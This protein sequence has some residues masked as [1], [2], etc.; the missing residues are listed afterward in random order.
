MEE[1]KMVR[2][3]MF[4]FA[5]FFLLANFAILKVYPFDQPAENIDFPEL[6]NKPVVTENFRVALATTEGMVVDCINER[7]AKDVGLA[8]Y[9]GYK[10]ARDHI[11]PD[12]VGYV[13]LHILVKDTDIDMTFRC[14]SE[15][16]KNID[17]YFIDEFLGKTQ[18]VIMKRTDI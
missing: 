9:E 13:Y 17:K 8:V 3:T 7:E 2:V 5:I 12:L 4:I 6:Q 16:V 15:V 10:F 14:E 1:K 11:P 18:Y